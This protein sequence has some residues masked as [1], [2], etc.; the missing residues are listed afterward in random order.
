MA[1]LTQQEQV[2]GLFSNIDDP[3]VACKFLHAYLAPGALKIP[4]ELCTRILSKD[5]AVHETVKEAHRLQNVEALDKIYV[6]IQRNAWRFQPHLEDM[7]QLLMGIS[8]NGKINLV[9][10]GE[11]RRPFWT[12]PKSLSDDSHAESE[13]TAYIESL[14]IPLGNPNKEIP[15]I[16]LHELGGFQYNVKLR[17]RL[18]RIFSPSSH[19]FLVNTSGTGKTKLLFEGLCMHW[20]FY[21]TC[22]I[23]SFNLG[24]ADFPLAV[25]NLNRN[26]T[27][28][29]YLPSTS[30]ANHVSLLQTNIRLV[31]R[32][33]SEVLLTRLLIFRMYLEAC[34]KEGF[35]LQQRQ[36]WLELQIFPKNTISSSDAFG[37]LKYKIT[38]AGLS[39]DDLDKAIRHSWD[40]IQSF[41]DSPEMSTVGDF[42]YIALDEANVASRK[43]D[44]AFEDHH[45]RYPILK[46][47]IRGL[48]RQTGHLPIRFVVAGTIIPEN[49]F[50]SL[51]G[52]WDDFRWCSDTGSFN[53]P[54]DHRR[55]VSQFMP[56]T[57]ASSVTGQALIDRMWYW[58][59]GRHRYTASFLAVLLHSNFT[60][61]HTL[62]GNYIRNFTEYAPH[63]NEEYSRGEEARYNNW[64]SPLGS[65]G[66]L[67]RSLS[68][69]EMHRAVIAFLTTARGIIDCSTK[70]RILITEDYGYFMDP[71]CSQIALDEPLTVTY[72]AGW[73]K[74]NSYFST[75]KF[76]SFFCNHK[77]DDIK[78]VTPSHY[79]LYLA[80]TFVSTLDHLCDTSDVF[81]VIG[82]PPT[83]LPQ[84][85]LVTFTT[86]RR[87][88]AVD[89]HPWGE[90]TYDRLVLMA[91]SQEETLSWFKHERDEPFCVLQHPSSIGLI[92]VFCLQLADAR[93]FWVFVHISSTH[94]NKEDPNIIQ[95]IKD[96]H[97][98]EVFRDQ[99]EIL[100]LLS[101]LPN[102]CLDVGPFGVLRVSGSCWPEKVMKDSIPQELFPAGLLNIEGLDEA[103]KRVSHDMLMRRLSQIIAQ[104]I[105]NDPQV[106]SPGMVDENDS[107][108]KGKRQR[109]RSSTVVDDTGVA[110]SGTVSGTRKTKSIK[111]DKGDDIAGPSTSGNRRTKGPKSTNVDSVTLGSSARTGKQR[112]GNGRPVR[113]RRGQSRIGDIATGRASAGLPRPEDSN[114]SSLPST[115]PYNLRKR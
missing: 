115:F 30:S 97:P 73:L 98:N 55:Y 95:D 3:E 74:K 87:L 7:N 114:S 107:H 20:G 100:S 40:E 99:P 65:K 112:K 47:L 17:N 106:V 67:E 33:V 68:T 48:R 105:K 16:I 27:W 6:Y 64:Y 110:P 92:L 5:P 78:E 66:L 103:D 56:V 11:W 102:L 96:L 44:E 37:M 28:T 94:T 69:A 75:R 76:I 63:D 60:S 85:K 108:Q 72:G 49:H 46:E 13:T 91:S 2:L 35:C 29:A 25:S 26:S 8:S 19:T 50:Q 61:P 104:K 53:D 22:A 39:D 32:A 42:L 80:L 101:E 70:D 71:E 54:E 21:M 83:L 10:N 1:A 62:L 59:R 58:L 109:G 31:Y 23:D 79:A 81:T 24:A 82:L 111:L 41:W 15:L 4:F 18:D 57:F 43:Y 52:E 86:T 34:A 90:E 12:P 45:G 113:F 36:R 14:H 38:R 77:R 88:K 93:C 51:V 89:V 9:A 84:V